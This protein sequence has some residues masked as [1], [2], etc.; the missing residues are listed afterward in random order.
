MTEYIQQL[1]NERPPSDPMIRM[2]VDLGVK[3]EDLPTRYDDAHH[4][5]NR[6][7]HTTGAPKKPERWDHVWTS[8]HNRRDD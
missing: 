2:L 8:F 6:L 7:R 3:H 4:L 5:I 1:K